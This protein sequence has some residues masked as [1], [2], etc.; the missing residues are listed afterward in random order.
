M[1]IAA[2][3]QL[4]NLAIPAVTNLV[5]LI[6]D[7]SGSTTAIISSTQQANAQDIAQIQAWLQAHQTPPAPAVSPSSQS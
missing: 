3:L 7:A 4:L 1:N 6:K 5:L 2:I